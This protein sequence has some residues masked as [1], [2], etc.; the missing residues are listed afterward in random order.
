MLGVP[1][2]SDPLHVVG[3]SFTYKSIS[4][5]NAFASGINTI[6]VSIVPIVEVNPQPSTPHPRPQT[7][8]PKPSTPNLKLQTLNLNPQPSTLNPKPETLN[9]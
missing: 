9:P 2:A 1:L 7:L 6:T 3:M 4:Q 8:N 5:S